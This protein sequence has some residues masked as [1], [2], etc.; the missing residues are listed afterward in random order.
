MGEKAGCVW[1]GIGLAVSLGNLKRAYRYTQDVSD[2]KH[3][4]FA[5][6]FVWINFEKSFAMGNT[7]YFRNHRIASLKKVGHTFPKVFID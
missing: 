1:V 4:A 6:N 3:I 7:P 2:K 5:E